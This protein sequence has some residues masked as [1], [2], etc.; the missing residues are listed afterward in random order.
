MVHWETMDANG[1]MVLIKV[2]AYCA[3]TI[4]MHLLSPQDYTQYHEID[5]EHAYLGNA[6][7]MQQQIATP[8]H[9]PGEQTSTM[10]VHANICMGAQL[11]FL[12]GSCHLPTSSKERFKT[13][14][15]T[16]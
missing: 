9:Q 5:T 2:P 16:T 14:D 11:P 12:A 6:D 15:S 4:E 1:I 3:P 7:F 10:T 13:C 8:E